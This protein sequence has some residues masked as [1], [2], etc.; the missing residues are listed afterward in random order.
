MKSMFKYT[1]KWLLLVG[2][3]FLSLQLMA[4]PADSVPVAE[5]ASTA[6]SPGK[7]QKIYYINLSKEIM[8]AAGRL[9]SK[10]ITAAET[11]EVDILILNLNTYGGRLDV[12]D[13]IRSRLLY[14][15]AKTIAFIN[16]NAA[17]AGAL[18]SLAC[19][20]IY[21]VPGASIG[22]ATVVDQAGEE[23]PDK[24]QSYMRG[25][26][27]STA[28]TKGRDPRIAEAMVDASIFIEGIIDSGKVLTL[29]AKEAVELG[30]A[31]GMANNMQEVIEKL[32]IT[33][34]TLTEHQ[35]SSLDK[36]INFLLNP[37]VNSILL[38][39]IVGGIY[40]EL[41]TP[42]V[43]FPLIAALIGAILY[44]APL[45]IDGSAAVW[46]VLLF[47]IGVILLLVEIFVI[48]GFG[49]AGISG[50]ILIIAGLT[51]SLVGVNWSDMNFIAMDLLAR[52]FFRV[53]LTF[54]GGMA[55]LFTFGG[56][57]LSL[58]GFRRMVLA[59]DQKS[60][61]GYSTRRNELYDLIGMEAETI[62]TLRPSGKVL[63]NGEIY[64]AVSESSFIDPKTAVIIR[65]VEGYSL[66]VRRKEG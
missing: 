23:V 12:A 10:A 13:S 27:R 19:D 4:N 33:E 3:L 49:V 58:P 45:L 17:S 47:I 37:I 18:I 50:I 26:M 48:P 31:D 64:D 42:G 55:L 14:S 11:E 44:F 46:E 6:A 20:S 40:F 62:S 35:E 34:Y 24:Y 7:K 65:A 21:M 54:I 66:L 43:G 63:L 9:I 53:M 22:A 2:G 29:T 1:P 5:T 61:D 25:M 32:G 41:K 16:N 36:F 60:E 59:E 30:I 56:S 52:A 51:F 15:K 38:L 39:L 8:P 57:A 28:E